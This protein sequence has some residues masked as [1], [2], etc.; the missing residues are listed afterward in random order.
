MQKKIIAIG[1]VAA[2]AT[3]PVAMIYSHY[4]MNIVSPD[5]LSHGDL[6]VGMIVGGAFGHNISRRHSNTATIAGAVI[7]SAIGH[8]VKI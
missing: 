1:L 7:G 5:F 4:E 8:D 3:A 6:A 2:L